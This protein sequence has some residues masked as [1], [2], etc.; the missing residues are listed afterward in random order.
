MTPA[1]SDS[2]QKGAITLLVAMGLVMLA[3]LASFYSARSVLV[4][5]LT[6]RNHAHAA[7]ARMAA[8]AAMAR[9]QIALPSTAAGLAT[10]LLGGADC[11]AGHTGPQW[12]CSQLHPPGHP[13]MPQAELSAIALRDLVLSPHVLMLQA[14]A[15][16]SAQSSAALTRESVFIPALAPAPDLATPAALVV[17][18]CVGEAPGAHLRVC[19]LVSNG[20]ACMGNA[21]G[22]AVQTH[23]VTDTNR[24]G[25]ISVAEKNACLALTPSSLPGAGAQTAPSTAQARQPCNRAAWRS[26]LGDISDA[27]LR[28]LSDAQQRNG[29]TEHTTPARTIYWIDS[30][31][32]WQLSVGSADQPVVLAFSATACAQRCPS[33]STSARRSGGGRYALSSRKPSPRSTFTARSSANARASARQ[34][35]ALSSISTMR[36]PCRCSR[37]TS[38]GEPG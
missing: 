9:V 38:S 31:R 16:L 29:L 2:P 14:S 36:S 21:R 33:I 4:D 25:S 5:Q 20:I 7:Q 32:E 19:P 30:P 27:Q 18:G 15:R 23:F 22:P 26:V 35:S 37:R 6:T 1:S 28:A 13:A 3:S 10:V 24:D 11:P 34:S 12:E 8:D 17:N